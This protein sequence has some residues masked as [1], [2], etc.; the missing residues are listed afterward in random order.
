[1]RTSSVDAMDELAARTVVP[2]I[3]PA[4]AKLHTEDGIGECQG[5]C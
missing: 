3:T 1:M 2:L 4:P 5:S